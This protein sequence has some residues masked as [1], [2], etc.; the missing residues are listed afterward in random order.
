[1]TRN[2]DGRSWAIGQGADGVEH[3]A[4][5]AAGR[6]H[7]VED[8]WVGEV[9]P[10]QAV[11][12]RRDRRVV[13]H[14]LPD[15]VHRR[16]EP[17]RESLAVGEHAVAGSEPAGCGDRRE[18]VAPLVHLLGRAVALLPR[19]VH[20]GPVGEGLPAVRDV[21]QPLQVGGVQLGDR[22]GRAGPRGD[23]MNMAAR[24]ADEAPD[25]P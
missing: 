21:P 2:A 14:D 17:A 11:D 1:V 24:T 10:P 18:L 3:R 20:R 15:Q 9:E 13:V 19:R 16:E 7:G 4:D 12:V 25:D 6:E 8:L 23:S 5:E 22:A